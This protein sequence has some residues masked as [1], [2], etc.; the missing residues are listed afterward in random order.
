MCAFLAKEKI[1]YL[2]GTLLSM[3]DMQDN[4]HVYVCG[5]MLHIKVHISVKS[6]SPLYCC[7]I[8]ILFMLRSFMANTAIAK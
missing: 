8:C 7:V 5:K 4:V 1:V 6:Y 3:L 2:D